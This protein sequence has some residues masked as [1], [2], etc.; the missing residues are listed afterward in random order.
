NRYKHFRETI[1]GVLFLKN[2][3]I[4]NRRYLNSNM[5][6]FAI[7]NCNLLANDKFEKICRKLEI[8][9]KPWD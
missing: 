6:Y 3:S 7:N 8:F 1:N 9:L 5:S 4:G 2:N